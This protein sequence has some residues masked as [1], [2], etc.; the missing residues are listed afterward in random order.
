MMADQGIT[1]ADWDAVTQQREDPTTPPVETPPEPIQAE[2]APVAPTEEVK[3]QDPYEGLHPDVRARL[4]RFDQLEA[5]MPQLINE[6]KSA[7]GRVKA[8]QSE[9]DKAKAGTAPSQNQIAAA[10]KDSE[11]WAA[12]KQDFPEWGEGISEYVDSRLGQLAGSG[13][14]AE[15]IEQMVADR[16]NANTAA[17]EKKFN[18]ALVSVKHKNWKQDV[19]TPEFAAWFQAQDA[20]TK[21]LADSTDGFDAIEML[22]RFQADKAKPVAAVKQDRQRKLEQAVTSASKPGTAPVAKSFEDMTPE[23]QWNYLA[24]N[25]DKG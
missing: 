21:A 1:Q 16:A 9:W 10:A 4:E 12:L 2:A 24:Q 14:S 25:R 6:L 8:L 22:D 15:Q 13:L 17:L 7:Q 5:N 23:E 19:K 3:P 11:K 18:E 20:Q